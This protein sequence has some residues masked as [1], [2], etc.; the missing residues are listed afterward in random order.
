MK[1]AP[2]RGLR[3]MKDFFRPIE[4]DEADRDAFD[5]AANMSY[6][7]LEQ[8]LSVLN[9]SL[10]YNMNAD[11]ATVKKTETKI[12]KPTETMPMS[13]E[14][15]LTN[16]IDNY[17]TRKESNAK[18]TISSPEERLEKILNIDK[19]PNSMKLY[20][21]KR[22]VK[23]VR[24]YY[25]SKEKND[26]EM[27][28]CIEK[29]FGGKRKLQQFL[30][31]KKETWIDLSFSRQ[32]TIFQIINKLEKKKNTSKIESTS[33]AEEIETHQLNEANCENHDDISQS[34]YFFD[35][36]LG[37][38]IPFEI[39][40]KY[41]S[42]RDQIRATKKH[43]VET[44][45]STPIKTIKPIVNKIH[46]PFNSS[47]I[48]SSPIAKAFDR[49]RFKNSQL[50]KSYQATTPVKDTSKINNGN[51]ETDQNENNDPPEDCLKFLGLN[52]IDDLFGDDESDTDKKEPQPMKTIELTTNASGKKSFS[53]LQS[54]KEN[55]TP[56][57]NSIIC[58]P[59]PEVSDLFAD[60]S[61]FDALSLDHSDEIPATQFHDHR[62]TVPSSKPTQYTVSQI[63][64]ICEEDDAP[65][66]LS[67][68]NENES[69]SDLTDMYDKSIFGSEALNPN[70]NIYIGSVSDLF[71]YD[72]DSDVEI[73]NVELKKEEIKTDETIP[74]SDSDCTEDYDFNDVICEEIANKSHQ[75]STSTKTNGEFTKCLSSLENSTSVIRNADGLRHH[76]SEDIFSMNDSKK[77]NKTKS[78]IGIEKLT[79]KESDNA[80]TALSSGS[81]PTF[82]KNVPNFTKSSSLIATSST[83][84]MQ[85]A[86]TSSSIRT[87]SP[88]R[89][90]T[91]NNVNKVQ[92]VFSASISESRSLS[93]SAS[94]ISASPPHNTDR[95]RLSIQSQRS[96][97][98]IGARRPNL[99]RLWSSKDQ[100]VSGTSN[101]DGSNSTPFLTCKPFN[102]SLNISATK[103]IRFASDSDDDFESSQN[104][105]DRLSECC[106]FFVIFFIESNYV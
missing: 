43:F 22:D 29:I 13:F 49:C 17:H 103:A 95:E 96:P 7:D 71:A 97:S 53:L 100:S 74:K 55:I 77:A 57:G 30:N 62:N 99:S 72:T 59:K 48:N 60:D 23:F 52:C 37:L 91:P 93:K 35:S 76:E 47:T 70:K 34:N 68:S 46:S 94:E 9:E 40:S 105:R 63:L 5:E 45:S 104:I 78:I 81:P 58:P 88:A 31:R 15:Q 10:R 101:K 61:A 90:S 19:V 51:A 92:P 66:P 75:I 67:A 18:S 80:I 54:N 4:L 38:P 69:R 33:F 65:K 2:V 44:L 11:S 32:L 73:E 21:L 106:D 26:L 98:V 83:S 85:K 8:N 64:K 6:Q 82:S 27:R 39:E 42:Q 20:F 56:K 50:E 14:E 102:N 3:S 86:E 41:E 89:N 25:D 16:L 24:K 1:V 87:S 28:K 84:F 36:Q 79:Q 12:S